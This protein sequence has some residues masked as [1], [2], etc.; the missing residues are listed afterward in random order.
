MFSV[1]ILHHETISDM[2][3]W[4]ILNFNWFNN[5]SKRM[6]KFNRPKTEG[7]RFNN[8]MFCFGDSLNHYSV[9]V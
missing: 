2:L 9:T 8:N 3:F 1:P 5:A 4:F 6:G 7:G